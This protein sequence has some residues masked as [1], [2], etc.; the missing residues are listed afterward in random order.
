MY[1]V[2]IPEGSAVSSLAAIAENDRLGAPA[3]TTNENP[4]EVQLM[5]E[6]RSSVNDLGNI[7]DYKETGLFV[8]ESTLQSC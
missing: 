3:Q 2:M 8:G 1:K 4:R 5:P 6:L 7:P